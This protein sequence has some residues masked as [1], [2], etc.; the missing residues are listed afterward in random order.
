MLSLPCYVSA[1]G[2]TPRERHVRVGARHAAGKCC[3][4]PQLYETVNAPCLCGS[5]RPEAGVGV[6]N[7][8]LTTEPLEAARLYRRSLIS[9]PDAERRHCTRCASPDPS[10]RR[11]RLAGRR[12]RITSGAE[13]VVLGTATGPVDSEVIRTRL[14]SGGSGVLLQLARSAV[15]LNL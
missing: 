4:R 9:R 8:A 3:A 14:A 1:V 11:G 15:S 6:D 7:R 2:G 10:I 12:S 13:V 5:P